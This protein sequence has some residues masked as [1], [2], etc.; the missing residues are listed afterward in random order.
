MDL[1]EPVHSYL[2][3][4]YISEETN[5][6]VAEYIEVETL[7]SFFNR[8]QSNGTSQSIFQR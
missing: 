3:E 6:L 4:I 2:H 1:Y 7:F 5:I 8:E